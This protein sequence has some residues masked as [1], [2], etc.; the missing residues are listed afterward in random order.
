MDRKRML[1]LLWIAGAASLMMACGTAEQAQ[2]RPATVSGVQLETVR[3]ESLPELYQA[4]G[5]VESATSSVVGAEISGTVRAVLVQAG[6]HVRRGQVL[7]LLD[8][9]N[10]RAQVGAAQAGV[11]EA[12]QGGAEV[13]QALAAATAQRQF[14]EA[15]FKRYQALLAE[16]SVSQQEFDNAQTQYKAALANERA[17]EAKQNQLSARRRQA[18]A[19]LSSAETILSYARVVSPLDGVVA[20][21]DVDAGTLVM[22]GTPLFTVD[23]PAHY[24]LRAGLPAEFAG[25][26]KRGE[27][28]SV[29]TAGKKLSGRVVE[30]APSTDP[31]SRTMTVKVELPGDCGCQSGDYGTALFPVGEQKILAVPAPALVEQG[32]LTGVFAVGADGIVEYRLVKTGRTLGERVEILSG[33][34]GGERIAVSKLDLLKQG[35]RVEKP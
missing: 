26:V 9:R 32:Q 3:S 4:V 29:E 22:P 16:N 23:D 12:Q 27:E 1:K 28:V 17:V 35:V 31:A 10:P 18:K 6:D 21:K 2:P 15:T 19:Q 20:A 14:A 30:V 25:R 11:E 33:L 24:R 5:T 34:T 8:D 7:A 13:E